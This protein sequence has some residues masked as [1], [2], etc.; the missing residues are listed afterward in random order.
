MYND[1]LVE[2]GAQAL[3]IS[4]DHMASHRAWSAA[5]GGLPYP[6]LSDFHPKG[7]VIQ[8]YDLWDEERGAGRRAVLIVDKDGIIRY[9][10]TYVA[11][12]LPDMDELLGELDKLGLP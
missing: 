12:H 8:A 6:E 10:K 5:M 11:P 7:K 9:R 1:E 3:G 2:R 4:T